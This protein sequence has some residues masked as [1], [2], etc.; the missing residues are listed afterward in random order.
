MANLGW[1][2]WCSS[3]NYGST[4]RHTQLDKWWCRAGCVY[5]RTV[6]L[7]DCAQLK[8]FLLFLDL[9]YENMNITYGWVSGSWTHASCKTDNC[10]N[11]KPH[12]N[13]Y[14]YLISHSCRHKISPASCSYQIH[15]VERRNNRNQF[16]YSVSISSIEKM[17][18]N[19]SH[20]SNWRKYCHLSS[21]HELSEP[22]TRILFH[23]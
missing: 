14:M 23:R 12:K 3:H 10:H 1:K 18:M 9:V 11:V 5:Q 4:R 17:L 7:V 2:T 13:H 8:D 6:R 19:P 21:C 22:R 15:N 16:Q 20:Y